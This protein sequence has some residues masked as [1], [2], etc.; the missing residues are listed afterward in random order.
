MTVAAMEMFAQVKQ[1]KEKCAEK[2]HKGFKRS[3]GQLLIYFCLF[4]ARV[5]VMSV[6]W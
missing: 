6:A 4:V 5:L 2:C 1:S 3:D